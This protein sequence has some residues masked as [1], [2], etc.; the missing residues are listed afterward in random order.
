MTVRNR[1]AEELQRLTQAAQEPLEAAR[2]VES[3]RDTRGA[4]GLTRAALERSGGEAGFALPEAL[5][6]AVGGS[7]LLGPVGGI[8]LGVGQGILGK[9][10]KQNALDQFAAQSEVFDNTSDAISMQLDRYAAQAQTPEDLAVIDALQTQAGTAIEMMR[11]PGLQEKGGALLEDF[12]DKLNSYAATNEEQRIA[13]EQYRAELERTIGKE[14]LALYDGMISRF[15]NQ[16]ADYETI[17]GSTNTALAALDGGSPAQIS[18][19]ATLVAKALDPRG[20][21]RP[22]DEAKW[23]TMGNLRDRFLAIVEQTVGDGGTTVTQRN[24]MKTIIEDIRREANKIQLSREARFLNEAIDKNLPDRLLDNFTLVDKLDQNAN[25]P[26]PEEQSTGERAADAVTVPVTD[27]IE[28]SA[29]WLD[30]AIEA[31]RMRITN[32]LESV[33]GLP[34]DDDEE[35]PTRYGRTRLPTN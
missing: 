24:E 4:S 20:V 33:F 7:F 12:Y 35:R 10:A 13:D 28:S 3:L 22:E 15:E 5:V 1:A 26:L 31:D 27:A 30:R 11:T 25:R 29:N 2:Q 17:I 18:G 8:L 14:Q 9:E 23:S 6:T 32:A 19:A 21:V 34:G 16:S